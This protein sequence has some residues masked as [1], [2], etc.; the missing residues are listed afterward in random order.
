MTSPRD[1]DAILT[2]I[3]P[4]DR[5]PSVGVQLST[6]GTADLTRTGATRPAFGVLPPARGAQPINLWDKPINLW[7]NAGALPET[8]ETTR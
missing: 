2:G 3:R 5:V 6:D 1:P 8:W 7:D 4:A